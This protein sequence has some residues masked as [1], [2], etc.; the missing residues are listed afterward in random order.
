MRW[1]QNTEI[2]LGI[3]VV[4]VLIMMVIPLPTFLLDLLQTFSISLGLMILLTA[5]YVERPVEFYIFPSILLMA[6]VF[7]LALNVSST[8]LILLQGINFGGKVI[9][10]FG[11]FV[12]GGNYVVGLVIFA[13]LVIVQFVVITRGAVRISE[14]A[15]RFTLDAMPGRQME[16]TSKLNAGLITEQEAEE[17]LAELRKE[18]DFYGAMDGASR[19]VQGD[20]IAGLIITLINIIGGI[21]I[22]TLQR[23]EP[24]AEAARTYVLLTVGD[25]LVNQIPALLVSTATGIVVTRASS[26]ASFAAEIVKQFMI[27]PRALFIVSGIL[28]FFAVFTPLPTVPLLALAVV[29]ALLGWL[30][31]RESRKPEE[32]KAPPPEAP[33]PPEAAWSLVQVEPVTLEIGVGLIPLVDPE[34]GGDL[35]GKISTMRRQLALDLGFVVPPIRIR[36]DIRLRPDTYL[37]KIRG[38][39]AARGSVHPDRL[40]AINPG[41][42]KEELEGIPTRDPAYGQPAYWITPD[43]R[44]LAERLGYTVVEPSS[45]I[46][47]HLTEVIKR[48]ADQLFTREEV[49]KLLDQLRENYRAVV[50]SVERSDVLDLGKLQKVFQNLLREGIPIRDSVSILEA[51]LDASAYTQDPDLLTSA[52]RLALAPVISSLYADERGTINAIALDP[53]IE[54]EIA[55]GIQQT[56]EGIVVSVSP[57]L[58]KKLIEEM[59]KTL[60]SWEYYPPVLVVSTR[61]RP[62]VAKIL[63]RHFPEL[64]VISYDE[65]ANGYRLQIGTTVRFY[66]YQ[67]V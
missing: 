7:R 41:E 47:T 13:I 31:L 62:V 10:A 37:I 30:A 46:A 8:R 27:Y 63:R 6:T 24:L 19:F 57:E 44:E 5:L 34:Q 32:E 54:D 9:R 15:A 1:I 23:G 38:V 42:V 55:A 3:G 40:L 53:Q 28:V 64:A 20:V 60:S 14:V 4:T 26:R 2:L 49:R 56:P 50:E 16:I 36:D 43:N 61:V 29:A 67:K 39:E 52:A 59:E 48:K 58:E 17:Q 22:G 35:L 45:V 18:A 21:A 65:I 11:S 66:G 33:E 51:V 25:G 12:V